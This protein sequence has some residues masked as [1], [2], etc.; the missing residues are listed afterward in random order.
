M[1]VRFDPLGTRFRLLLVFPVLP[2]MVTFV[3]AV[4]AVLPARR[5]LPVTAKVWSAA[6][7]V[8]C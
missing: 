5:K 3:A 2:V 1:W 4:A 6:M 7:A 8:V